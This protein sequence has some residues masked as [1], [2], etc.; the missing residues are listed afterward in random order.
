MISFFA[1]IDDD[2]YIITTTAKKNTLFFFAINFE[3]RTLKMMMIMM[4]IIYS[5]T[6]K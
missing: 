4:Q 5:G 2:Q 1:I 3:Y 6:K